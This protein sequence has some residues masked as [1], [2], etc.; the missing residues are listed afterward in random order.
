M[1]A[2]IVTLAIVLAPIFAVMFWDIGLRR[3]L[4]VIGCAAALVWWTLF[5]VYVGDKLT[6]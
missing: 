4:I 3:G 6:R 2:L 5:A 1:K